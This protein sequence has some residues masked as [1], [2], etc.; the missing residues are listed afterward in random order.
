MKHLNWKPLCNPRSLTMSGIWRKPK[1]IAATR[2]SQRPLSHEKRLLCDCRVRRRDLHCFW[3]Y[4]SDHCLPLCKKGFFH[5]FLQTQLA[6]INSLKSFSGR[7]TSEWDKA[8][9][10]S[11]IPSEINGWEPLQYRSKFILCAFL[12]SVRR[13][14]IST[15]HNT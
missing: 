6:L 5:D 12:K 10:L 15:S 8:V 1:S 2:G 14:F 4:S 13:G 11:C 9:W 7:H 3:I